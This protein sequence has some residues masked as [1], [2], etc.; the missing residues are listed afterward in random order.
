M[1][2]AEDSGVGPAVRLEPEGEEAAA[3]EASEDPK[4]SLEQR[5]R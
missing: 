5:S 1:S 2:A 4:L 3:G